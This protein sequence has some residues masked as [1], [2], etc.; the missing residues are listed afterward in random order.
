MGE[1]M[2]MFSIRVPPRLYAYLTLR[3][4]RIVRQHLT[5]LLPGPSWST[6]QSTTNGGKRS[7][8]VF[9]DGRFGGET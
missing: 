8:R 7:L 2:K 5:K 1:A 3:G 4:S 6:S 9:Y